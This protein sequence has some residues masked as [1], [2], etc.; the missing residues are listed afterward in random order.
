[1]P[2]WRVLFA[3]EKNQDPEELYTTTYCKL[4]LN[5]ASFAKSPS[6]AL[7]RGKQDEKYVHKLSMDMYM[8]I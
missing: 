7:H 6:Y 2:G 5:G 4:Q 3:A 8:Y 1:M